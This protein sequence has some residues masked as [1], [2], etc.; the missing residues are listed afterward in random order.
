MD[1]PATYIAADT[2][3]QELQTKY[4]WLKFGEY[5]AVVA[6]AGA[7]GLAPLLGTWVYFVAALSL[8]AGLITLFAD[9]QQGYSEGWYRT[10]ALA[11]ATKAETWK[12]CCAYGPYAPGTAQ[13]AAEHSFV[14]TLRKIQTAVNAEPYVAEYRDSRQQEITDA[15]REAWSDPLAKRKARYIDD[16]ICY[17]ADWYNSRAKKWMKAKNRFFWAVVCLIL[18]GVVLGFLQVWYSFGGYSFVET[19]AALAAS[20]VGWSQLR[21]YESLVLIYSNSAREL[22]LLNADASHIDSQQSLDAIV[23]DVELVI[24]KEHTVWV[25]KGLVL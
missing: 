11:E 25:H 22:G 4:L 5:S 3:A 6:A 24:S 13:T 17:E 23:T 1:Y 2:A 16:R 21:R 18:F 12:F 20:L 9:R 14:A 15:M 19:F 7:A 10:R 8:L